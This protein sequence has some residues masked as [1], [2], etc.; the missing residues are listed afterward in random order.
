MWEE[1][2]AATEAIQMDILPTWLVI[3]V[4]RC[5]FQLPQLPHGTLET[6]QVLPAINPYGVPHN[7][8]LIS[9]LQ[10]LS[11]RMMGGHHDHPSTW[12]ADN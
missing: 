4:G 1:R 6:T 12:W 3:D 10:G 11:G 5:H 2:G 9:L 8:T 7:E